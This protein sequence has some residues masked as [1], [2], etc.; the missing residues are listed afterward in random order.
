MRAIPEGPFSQ[1]RVIPHIAT[2]GQPATSPKVKFILPRNHRETV[3][4]A[5][6]NYRIS[7]N[8]EK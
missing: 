2:P 5:K 6:L 7:E 8:Y 4:F 3:F 1:D